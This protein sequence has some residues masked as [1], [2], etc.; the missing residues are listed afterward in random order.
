MHALF[1]ALFALTAA[2]AAAQERL[3][4]SSTPAPVAQPATPLVTGWASWYGW[5]FHGRPT[6][7]GE[8]YDMFAMTAAHRTLPF[9][10][11]VR[12]S[13]IDGGQSVD[14]RI[15]DRGPFV[16]D[17]IIDL[18]LGAARKLDMLRSGVAQ[19]ELQVL[20]LSPPLR[21]VLQIGSFSDRNNAHD[22][23]RRLQ[24]WDIPATLESFGELTRIVTAPATE[25]ELPAI[26]QRLRAAGIGAWVR[27]VCAGPQT[28]GRAGADSPSV[29][30]RCITA[31][32]PRAPSRHARVP[33]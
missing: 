19:V 25:A 1:L 11:L 23:R 24:G 32:A 7:S 12:V 10:T 31:A 14:V 33:Q 29:P 17:R 9:H 30:G 20:R 8:D 22:L 15:N 4:A 28:E 16:D 27:R 3:P 2:G 26:E 5:Q 18:S 13:L 6:A 21:Y